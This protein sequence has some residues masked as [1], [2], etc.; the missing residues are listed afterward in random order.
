MWGRALV[1]GEAS[2]R[3]RR[4]DE[5]GILVRVDKPLLMN[6]WTANSQTTTNR[7]DYQATGTGLGSRIPWI[8]LTI[9]HPSTHVVD[10][11]ICSKCNARLANEI[12]GLYIGKIIY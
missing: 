12:P 10:R 1:V 7:F 2:R 4:S 5:P 6:S 3:D 9:F 11:L 8:K